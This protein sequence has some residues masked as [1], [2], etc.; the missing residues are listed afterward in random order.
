VIRRDAVSR[1]LKIVRNNKR[2][3]EIPFSEEKKLLFNFQ[4]PISS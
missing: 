1:S 2:L 4:G 3:T